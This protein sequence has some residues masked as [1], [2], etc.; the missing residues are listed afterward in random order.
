[1]LDEVV[2]LSATRG[3][4]KIERSPWCR[5]A[6]AGAHTLAAAGGGTLASFG[7]PAQGVELV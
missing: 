6:S 2:R 3:R 1:V 5:S 4:G 7:H